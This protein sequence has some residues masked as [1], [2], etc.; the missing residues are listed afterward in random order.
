MT[1]DD[2]LLE[3]TAEDLFEDAPCGYLTCAADGTIL[4]VN[5]TFEQLTGH[6]A[7]RCWA[8]ASATC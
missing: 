2:A 3:E 8:G 4:R 7:T 6:A 5:R 1:P